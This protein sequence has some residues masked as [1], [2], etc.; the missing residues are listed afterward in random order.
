MNALL[1]IASAAPAHDRRMK[2]NG[3]SLY[4]SPEGRW[5]RVAPFAAVAAVAIGFLLSLMVLVSAINTSHYLTTRVP[6]VEPL[7]AQAV[8]AVGSKSATAVEVVLLP[9]G[10]RPRL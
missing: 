8:S 10:L 5:T 7:A 3:S 6:K 2:M 4:P 9:G 1:R